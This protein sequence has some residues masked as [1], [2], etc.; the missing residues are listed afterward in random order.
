MPNLVVDH[1]PLVYKM[2]GILESKL[3]RR[4]DVERGDLVSYG[5]IGLIA[6]S[7]AFDPARGVKFGTY[8]EKRIR[9]AMLDGLRTFDPLKRYHA[10]KY[11][12]R[13][14]MSLDRERERRDPDHDTCPEGGRLDPEPVDLMGLLPGMS[15]IERLM[16]TL[17]YQDGLTMT[18]T[19]RAIGLSESRIS[20]IHARAIGELW[21][22]GE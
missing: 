7:K 5:V 14:P 18:E 13:R 22:R 3:P 4:R 9:G 17:L 19:G 10:R 6:A 15:R 2:A 11:G 12:F 21:A 16:M 1:L 8:A 20:Q